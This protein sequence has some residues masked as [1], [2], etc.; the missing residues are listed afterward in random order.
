M[1]TS[2]RDQQSFGLEM[3]PLTEGKVYY[4]VGP[5]HGHSTY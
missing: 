1:N 5:G 4:D 3:K 2:L